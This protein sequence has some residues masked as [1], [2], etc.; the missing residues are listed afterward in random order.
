MA[1][2]S[3][4]DSQLGFVQESSYATYATPTRFIEFTDESLK[5]DITRIESKG[6]RAG[7]RVSHRWAA[8]TQRVNGDIN[9][10]LAPQDLGLLLENAIGPAQT[11]GA[12]PYVHVFEP[13]NL[14]A[15]GLVFQV[16]RPDVAGTDRVFSYLGCRINELEIAAKV[17]EYVTARLGIYGADEDRAQSLASASYDASYSPFV[18]THGSVSLAGSGY[19][20]REIT[21]KI[22]NNLLTD[23]HFIRSTTPTKPKIAIENTRRMISGSFTGDFESLTAYERFV[24]AGEAALVLT[25]NAGASAILAITM[26][27]RFNGETPNVK[28]EE[29]LEQPIQFMV[30]SGTDDATAFSASLTNGDATA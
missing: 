11:T 30:T 6:L 17:D 22:E 7:R 29:V 21:L 16:N 28:G 19:D 24:N 25:F 20:V 18:F 15:T 27:V 5:L 13:G 8:G 23:R 9:F 12:G 3:G 4:L 14:P 1:L 10:E 2:A 26:N